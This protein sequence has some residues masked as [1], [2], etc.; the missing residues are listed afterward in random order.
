MLNDVRKYDRNCRSVNGVW[1]KETKKRQNYPDI[2]AKHDDIANEQYLIAV[3]CTQ[4]CTEFE[5]L[6]NRDRGE[7]PKYRYGVPVLLSKNERDQHICVAKKEN[8]NRYN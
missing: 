3:G 6:N 7:Y 1:R 5:T 8:D 4:R 2:Y